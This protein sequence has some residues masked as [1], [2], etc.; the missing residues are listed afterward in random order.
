MRRA[1][2]PTT[3]PP[4][5]V[6]LG[7]RNAGDAA[8]QD[9]AAAGLALEGVGAGLDRHPAGDLAH[10]REQRQSAAFVGDRLVGDGDA[11]GLE[12]PLRLGRVRREVEVGE[13]D[14]ALAQ[15][16]D[17]GRLRL[18]DLDHQLG[19]AEH[20][21]GVRHDLGAGGLIVRVVE[22]DRLARRRPGR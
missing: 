19:S 20:G 10:R 4:S 16:P 14:L 2:M 11:A 9:A 1:F 15:H 18:L 22:I 7:R 12:Q 17:L 5:T 21:R 8:E 3:P 6:D 13:Q